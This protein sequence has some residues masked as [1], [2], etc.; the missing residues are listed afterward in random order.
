MERFQEYR[1]KARQKLK[2]ADHMITMT[3]P[4]VRDTRLLLSVIENIFLALTNS[5]ASVLYYERLFKRIPPF[6]DTFDSK[7]NMFKSKIV[8]KYSVDKVYLEMINDIKD[9]I[10]QHKK[11]P[12][13]FTRK[14]VFVIAGESYALK[15]VTVDQI[16]KYI[17]MSKNFISRMEE[18]VSKDEQIFRTS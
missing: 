7:L 18:I 4:L 14:D 1:E 13:E 15:T 9:I 10:I 5:I 11:S 6:H 16:K 8:P 3:Y 17:G 2:I 12:V